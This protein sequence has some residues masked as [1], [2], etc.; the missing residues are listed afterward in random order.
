VTFGPWV[1]ELDPAERIARIRAI[2]ALAGVFCHR[3]PSSGE[4]L[5]RA[6]AEPAALEE[7]L[8][9]L[10]ELPALNRRRLLASCTATATNKR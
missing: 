2:R 3:F 1:T 8:R 9:L 7:A 4:A 5:L 6:E 10:D